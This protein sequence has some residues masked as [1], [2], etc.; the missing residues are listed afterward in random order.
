MNLINNNVLIH[1][2]TEHYNHIRFPGGFKLY[3]DTSFEKEKHACTSGWIT[4]LPEKLKYPK[5]YKPVIEAEIGDEVIFNYLDMSNGAKK[6]NLT[7]KGLYLPYDFLYAVIRDGEVIPLN[8]WLIIEEATVPLPE[9][10]LFIPDVCKKKIETKGIIRYAGASIQA[11][12]NYDLKVGDT[13][14]FAKHT[15]LPLQ[16]EMHQ[17]ISPDRPLFRVRYEDVLAVITEENKIDDKKQ[18]AA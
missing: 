9:T 15:S 3:L 6:G 5:G 11:D 8:G 2:N 16:Y 10:S 14:A 1:P 4:E 7:E 13:I 18:E 12:V 17:L